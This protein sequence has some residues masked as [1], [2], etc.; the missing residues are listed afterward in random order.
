[1]QLLLTCSVDECGPEQHVCR[2]PLINEGS[3][4]LSSYHD[5]G[6]YHRVVVMRDHTHQVCL[7]EIE[8]RV[9][10]VVVTFYL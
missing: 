10:G 8:I 3:M 4:H 6:Y 9:W 5:D 2:A 7:G 1:M